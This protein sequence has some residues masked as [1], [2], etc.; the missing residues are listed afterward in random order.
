[1]TQL[2][3]ILRSGIPKLGDQEIAKFFKALAGVGEE[4]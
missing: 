1:M 2:G 4:S 3:H